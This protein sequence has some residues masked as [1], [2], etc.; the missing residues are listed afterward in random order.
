MIC[1]IEKMKGKYI[2]L[3]EKNHSNKDDERLGLFQRLNDE[4]S[5]EKVLYPGS[6]AHITPS[7]VFHNVIYNDTYKKLQ[8]FYDSDEIFQYICK[9]KEYDGD[10]FYSYIQS[11]RLQHRNYIFNN[12]DIVFY[13]CFL[14]TR[15]QK[16]R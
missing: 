7:F 14:E 8:E 6:Y 16:N 4:Y 1:S 13:F 3:Y 10:P 2:A 15:F 12:R 5:I 11:S 9:R